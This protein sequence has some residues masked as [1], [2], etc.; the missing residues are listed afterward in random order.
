MTILTRPLYWLEKLPKPSRYT[1]AAA[2]AGVWLAAGIVLSSAVQHHLNKIE[3]QTLEQA[4]TSLSAELSGYQVKAVPVA[5]AHYETVATVLA[6]RYEG[7]SVSAEK[8]GLR[9][10]AAALEDY[11]LFE[12]A[13]TTLAATGGSVRY[14]ARSLC[15][16]EGGVC[17]RGVSH[18]AFVEAESWGLQ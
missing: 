1:A 3:A 2:L 9:I 12:Q 7:L 13:L 6:A 18:A 15:T 17:G 10:E 11:P 5:Q 14:R 16:G 4:A 8:G